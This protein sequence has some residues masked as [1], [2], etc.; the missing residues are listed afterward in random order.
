MCAQCSE[1]CGEDGDDNLTDLLQCLLRGFFHGFQ[2]SGFNFLS[3][4]RELE[5][6]F[7]SADEIELL[8]IGEALRSATRASKV[9]LAFGIAF[10]TSF[11]ACIRHLRSVPHE[12]L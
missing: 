1:Q 11:G 3:R 9:E 10:G 6:Y 4:I 2:D 8:R 5:N 12:F 7:C